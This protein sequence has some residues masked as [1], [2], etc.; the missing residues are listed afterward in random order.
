[1]PSRTSELSRPSMPKSTLLNLFHTHH[2][3]D[4]RF[5][6]SLGALN[7]IPLEI[8]HQIYTHALN[9]NR[10]TIQNHSIYRT[11]L[12]TNPKS[13]IKN[14]PRTSLLQTSRLVYS[15]AVIAMF[16]VNEWVLDIDYDSSS[17]PRN[18]C[19]ELQQKGWRIAIRHANID[20][21]E[22]ESYFLPTLP[23]AYLLARMKSVHVAVGISNGIGQGEDIFDNAIDPWYYPA[24][25]DHGAIKLEHEGE[26]VACEGNR[27]KSLFTAIGEAVEI[28]K[29]CD[30]LQE[31]K[32]SV[33]GTYQEVFEND[34]ECV[35][36]PFLRMRLG[37]ENP[38]LKNVEVEVFG[39]PM[40]W[41]VEVAYSM[42]TE[43][44]LWLGEVI[45]E[46]RWDDAWVWFEKTDEYYELVEERKRWVFVKVDRGRAYMG[47]GMRVWWK[48][49][50]GEREW[51]GV[52]GNVSC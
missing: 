5:Q 43:Y 8:R 3:P 31:F 37:K 29:I 34:I 41:G 19:K 45:R 36:E 46:G 42:T 47:G 27:W 38:T 33:R 32:L 1:M 12:P 4:A 50:C 51:E 10:S 11:P 52:D 7:L 2:G 44:K 16:E 25:P 13:F 24:G 35:L 48:G 30:S 40:E 15:E 20:R 28:L 6:K 21:A 9:F 18:Q 23:P 22:P 14:Q 49:E 17:Y 39:T 26:C